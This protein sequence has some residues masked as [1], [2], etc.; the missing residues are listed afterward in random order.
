[1][2]TLVHGDDYASAGDDE[3]LKWLE[4]EPSKAYGLQC[5]KLG[6]GKGDQVEAEVLNRIIRCT[7]NGWEAEADPR[8]AELVVEQLGLDNEQGVNTPCVS[9]SEEEDVEED[10]ELTGDG[11]TR[12][13]GVVA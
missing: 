8:H 9:G 10:S 1:M 2:K 4:A 3:L 7:S 6:V 12:Y 5:Q 11:I 13:W